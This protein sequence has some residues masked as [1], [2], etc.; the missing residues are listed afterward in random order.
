MSPTLLDAIDITEKVVLRFPF[1]SEMET[2]ETIVSVVMACT[3]VSGTDATPAATLLGAPVTVDAS[4][5]VLQ[6]V[7]GRVGAVV[8][9]F[10]C[11]ATLS[12]GRVLTRVSRLPVIDF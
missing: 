9:K 3:L 12:S 1:A 10:K 2:G 8:Y 5:E 11:S 7:Q 4:Q 6:R